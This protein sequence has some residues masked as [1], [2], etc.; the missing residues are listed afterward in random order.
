[1][2]MGILYGGFDSFVGNAFRNLRNCH[3]GI[4]IN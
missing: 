2:L 4:T 1:M 3:M